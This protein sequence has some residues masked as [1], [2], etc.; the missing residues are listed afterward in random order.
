M[1][2]LSLTKEIA[3]QLETVS[4]CAAFEARCLAQ[5]YLGLS[6]ND[7]LTDTGELPQMIWDAL[8]RS[9]HRNESDPDKE[10]YG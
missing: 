4:E 7:I 8:V 10:G 5:H 1:R 3:K 2:A 6:L 9:G